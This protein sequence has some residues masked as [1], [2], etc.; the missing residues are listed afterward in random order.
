LTA[1]TPRYNSGSKNEVF[2][3]FAGFASSQKDGS[4]IGGVS[5]GGDD[6]SVVLE[7]LGESQDNSAT[8]GFF[9]EI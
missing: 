7:E 1:E 8:D 5:W 9:D 4:Q 6:R 3:D 2:G